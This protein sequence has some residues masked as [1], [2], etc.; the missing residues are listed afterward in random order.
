MR[1]TMPA[2]ASQISHSINHSGS[3]ASSPQVAPS[4]IA[5]VAANLDDSSSEDSPRDSTPSE[6]TLRNRRETVDLVGIKSKKPDSLSASPA[7]SNPL[8]SSALA[9][10]PDSTTTDSIT[11]SGNESIT[12]SISENEFENLSKKETGSNSTE[13]RQPRPSRRAVPLSQ[14]DLTA[15]KQHQILEEQ[16]L[17][18][19]E[20]GVGEFFDSNLIPPLPHTPSE[21]FSATKASVMM[22][23]DDDDDDYGDDD[24]YDMSD[25][26]DESFGEIVNGI[27]E[28]MAAL[29]SNPPP[30]TT[31]SSPIPTTTFSYPSPSPSPSTLS[32][33]LPSTP[34]TPP[35]PISSTPPVSGNIECSE[36][37]M[38][39][40][41]SQ[42]S[43]VSTDKP[44]CQNCE[45]L[46]SL[47][48]RHKI[49][50]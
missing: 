12:E 26:D 2:M 8:I 38:V 27:E 5:T 35:S 50:Q 49:K 13:K 41:V 1:T 34:P 4:M 40:P 20:K 21:E 28:A 14:E 15:L 45:K 32:P 16:T 36:C 22:D 6:N 25:D 47:K 18:H 37:G 44:L 11:D 43:G 42:M 23:D 24:E 33:N 46:S 31:T 7:P 9:P 3:H 10:V 29:E 17:A 19:K 48:K 39:F 30:P